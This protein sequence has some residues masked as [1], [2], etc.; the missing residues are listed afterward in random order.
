METLIQAEIGEILK[1]IKNNSDEIEIPNL[2]AP[3]VLNIL[4]G[5]ATGAS[6]SRSDPLLIKL[7]ELMDLRAK[8]FDMSGGVLSQH[9]W[10]RFVFP[11]WSGFN[12]IQ[13]INGKLKDLIMDSIH[14]HYKLW[15]EGREDDLIYRYI[16]E[17]K[18]G[19]TILTG[20]LT[21]FVYYF[22]FLCF[23]LDDQLVM[24]CLD[25]FIAGSMTTSATLNFTLLYMIFYPNV[26]KRIQ[27]E[28]DGKFKTDQNITY[29]DRHR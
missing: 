16:T 15:D 14:N 8:A 19:N 18:S 9:P 22:D 4:W 25:L 20:F 7:L 3:A 27:D 29:G 23:I 28:I 6:I 24:I 13:N 1:I 12:L 26:Q 17:M 5:L 2:M 11:N 21:H 10:I